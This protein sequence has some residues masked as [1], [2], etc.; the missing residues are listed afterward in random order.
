MTL[1]L[2]RALPSALLVLGLSAGG[3]GQG[4][5]NAGTPGDSTVAH[6]A[7]TGT[8]FTIVFENKDENA[9]LTP[10]SYFTQ[11]AHENG[12]AAAYVIGTHPSLPNYITMTSGA[13]QGITDDNDP[14]SHPLPGTDNLGSQLEA[15][16]VPWRAYAEGM[17]DACDMTS[18]G[19]YAAK[20]MPFVYYT[21]LTSN[22]ALC[23]DRVVDFDQN[24]EQDL[25][26]GTYK[27]MWITPNMCND[28]H[29]CSVSAGEQ[30]LQRV[31]PEIMASPG[32]RNNGAIFILWDEG[33]GP[34]GIPSGQAN[35]AALVLSPVLVSPG[36]QSSVRYDHT[37]YLATVE[38]ILGLP[39]LATTADATPMSDFFQTDSS[40]TTTNTASTGSDAAA[41]DAGSS[42]ATTGGN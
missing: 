20:H 25:A 30:W 15:A 27:Y 37:S 19:A 23:Q 34:F 24:F 39:R 26:A 7:V 1:L 32:Y 16:H 18:H 3:C 8:I 2:R 21:D 14:A 9:V 11:L 38:D 13:T 33:G 17:G 6:T 42:T 22:T 41:S 31:L 5:T 36:F 4:V 12:S 28:M 40:T 10:S 35:V 29:D